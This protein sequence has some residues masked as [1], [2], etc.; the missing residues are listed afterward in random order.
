[1]AIN[2]AQNQRLKLAGIGNSNPCFTL[3][4]FYVTYSQVNTENN[5]YSYAL[6]RKTN[7]VLYKK[8]L[9]IYVKCTENY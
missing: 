7:N 1:M 5:F 2:K 3:D 4:Q 8:V 9:W 6:N